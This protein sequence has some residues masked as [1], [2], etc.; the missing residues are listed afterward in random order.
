VSLTPL[1]YKNF[2]QGSAVSPPI[3]LE[4]FCF[5]FSEPSIFCGAGAF[6]LVIFFGTGNFFDDFIVEYL[7]EFEDIFENILTLVSESQI[8]SMEKTKDRK[9]PMTRSL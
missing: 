6:R 2:V 9:T 8:N 4:K 7:C 1:N 5:F 3:Q